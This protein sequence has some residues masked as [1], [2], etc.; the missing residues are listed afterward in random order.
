MAV[1]KRDPN[2]DHPAVRMH[3]QIVRLTANWIQRKEIIAT[4]DEAVNEYGLEPDRALL[5]WQTVLKQYMLEGKRPTNV[6]YMLDL[7]EEKIRGPKWD[8]H[9][10]R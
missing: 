5:I 10:R 6:K 9:N 3:R 4:I 1:T 2:L 7:F 8:R